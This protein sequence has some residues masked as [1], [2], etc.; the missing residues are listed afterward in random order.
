MKAGFEANY[1]MTKD[2][3][4][5][6]SSDQ[7]ANQT[8]EFEAAGGEVHHIGQGVISTNLFK[9]A[10]QKQEEYHAELKNKNSH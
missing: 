1:E 7:I 8:A 9:S 5:I 3:E 6:I 4:S 10:K 2:K